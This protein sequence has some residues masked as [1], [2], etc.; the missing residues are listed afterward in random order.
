[1]TSYRAPLVNEV[2]SI[3]CISSLLRKCS[4]TVLLITHGIIFS[5]RY[6]CLNEIKLSCNKPFSFSV[7]SLLFLQIEAG[8]SQGHLWMESWTK[9]GRHT[10]TWEWWD[11]LI[12]CSTDIMVLLNEC[13]RGY[14]SHEM[15]YNVENNDIHFMIK[16]H[17]GTLNCKT[18]NSFIEN[19]SIHSAFIKTFKIGF[20]TRFQLDIIV[21]WWT[22]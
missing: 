20:S 19:Y 5:Y 10:S 1:M 22:C 15:Y 18:R 13:N 4:L 8:L 16:Y 11:G 21:F 14:H 2:L 6:T 3:Q 12:L 17:K 9:V 7:A